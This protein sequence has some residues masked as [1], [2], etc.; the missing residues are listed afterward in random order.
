MATTV[1]IAG[2]YAGEQAAGYIAP[3]ILMAN[4]IEQGLVT[5]H[6]RVAYKMNVRNLDA[7]VVMA[8]SSC[9]F[10]D[11]GQLDVSDTVLTLKDLMV[12]MEYC[13]SDLWNQ[14]ESVQMAGQRRQAPVPTSFQDFLLERIALQ[15]SK[16]IETYLWD[17]SN[18]AG[19]FEGLI[20]KLEASATSVKVTLPTL[21]AANII[22]QIAA[23]KDA[24]TT[25][26]KQ[27]AGGYSIM[28][29]LT[30]F[31]LYQRALGYGQLTGSTYIN[32]YNNNIVVDAKPASFEGIPILIANGIPNDTIVAGN[33]GNLH[34]G[35]NLSADWQRNGI[36]IVD[37]TETA[38]ELNVRIRQDFS[39]GTQI[40]NDADLVIANTSVS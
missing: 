11:A 27:A 4:S 7:T 35:T 21:T 23:V 40:T 5:L 6:E 2:N 8:D 26:V 16:L 19:Q 36:I 18:T 9:D 22:A 1:N 15:T 28:M 32:S 38:A 13:K 25:E 33:S 29:N 37:R 31:D 10:T 34:V 24:V 14:W 20:P 30:T 17:G 12:N 39:I 3:A